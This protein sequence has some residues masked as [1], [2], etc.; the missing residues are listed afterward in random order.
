MAALMSVHRSVFAKHHLIS[1]CKTSQSEVLLVM[2]RIWNDSISVSYHT[3]HSV[4][5]EAVE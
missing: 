5:S 2:G 4:C 3:L 1:P